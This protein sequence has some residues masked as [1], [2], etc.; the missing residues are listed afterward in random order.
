MTMQPL[1]REDIIRTIEGTGHAPEPR[2]KKRTIDKSPL[3]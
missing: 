2:Q 1:S 3:M